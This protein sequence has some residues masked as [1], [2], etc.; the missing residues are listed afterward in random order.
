MRV[1]DFFKVLS[2]VFIIAVCAHGILPYFQ[3]S[4]PSYKEWLPNNVYVFV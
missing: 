3:T 1:L 4:I 2:A